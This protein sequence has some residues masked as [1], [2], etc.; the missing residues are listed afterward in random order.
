MVGELEGA[1]QTVRGILIS[2]VAEKFGEV[3]P[4]GHGCIEARCR[5]VRQVLVNG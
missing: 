5:V 1:V 4:C 2:R 3:L